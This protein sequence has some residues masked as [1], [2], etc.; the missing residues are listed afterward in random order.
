MVGL[1]QI[2]EQAAYTDRQVRIFTK[3]GQVVLGMFAYVDEFEAD[4]ERLGFCIDVSEYESV[5]VFNDEIISI[6]IISANTLVM[7]EAI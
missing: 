5:V 7:A 2:L 6:E 4:P 3:T 1:Q